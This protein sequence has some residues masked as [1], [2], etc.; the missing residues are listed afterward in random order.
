MANVWKAKSMSCF[1]NTD[2]SFL[3]QGLIFNTQ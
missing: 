3:A 1:S 2:I